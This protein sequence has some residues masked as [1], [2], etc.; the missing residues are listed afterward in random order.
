[1]LGILAIKWGIYRNEFKCSFLKNETLIRNIL[2]QFNNVHN[3]L[4]IWKKR[5]AS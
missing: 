5:W 1:M 3:I 2:F 4:D